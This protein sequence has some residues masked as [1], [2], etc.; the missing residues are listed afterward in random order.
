MMYGAGNAAITP[1]KRQCVWRVIESPSNFP[2]AGGG[3]KARRRNSREGRAVKTIIISAFTLMAMAGAVY[4]GEMEGTVKEVDM[5][6][7]MIMLEDGMSVTT[8]MDV[9]LDSLK[10]G[11]KVKITT[12]DNKMGTMVEKM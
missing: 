7:H 2:C 10:A 12:D 11:D 6:K 4:A 1:R 3:M 5:E 8:N 9:K